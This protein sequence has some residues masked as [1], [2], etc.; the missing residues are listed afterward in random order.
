MIIFN[1]KIYLK[2]LIILFIF[3]TITNLNKK[4]L[5]INNFSNNIYYLIFLILILQK[6]RNI[7]FIILRFSN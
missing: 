6:N 3:I 4:N 2:I 7:N 1:F 5:I